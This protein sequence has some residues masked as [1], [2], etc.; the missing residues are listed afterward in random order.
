MHERVKCYSLHGHRIQVELTL[1]FSALQDIGY[2]IDFKEIKRLA[3]EWLDDVLDHGFIAN[4]ADTV[5]IDACKT[6]GSK[7]YLMSLNGAGQYCN[8][9]AENIAKEIF[10]TMEL[11]FKNYPLVTVH[12]IRFYETP[13]CWVDTNNLS[14]SAAERENF[15]AFRQ[16]GIADFASN[17]GVMEYDVRKCLENDLIA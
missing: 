9:T 16:Q 17:K 8:P 14:I 15:C 11:L 2:Q 7:Y 10:I 1:A 3:G 4:P 12:H 6:V 13:N 5:V